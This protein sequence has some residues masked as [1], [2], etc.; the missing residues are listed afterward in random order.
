MNIDM[1]IHVWDEGFH[2]QKFKLARAKEVA[3]RR[4]PFRDPLTLLPRIMADGVDPEGVLLMQEMTKAGIDA[5]VAMT[6]DVGIA[7]GDEQDTPVEKV[8][9]HHHHLT[10]KYKG[11]F[12]AFFGVDPRRPGALKLFEKSVREWDF[13]GL[14]LYP[15]CGYFPADDV[16]KPFLRTCVDLGV[17]VL[18]HT[19]ALVVPPL[20]SRYAHPMYVSDIAAEFPDL[21][22][23]YGHMGFPAWAEDAAAVAQMH[24]WSYM[25]LSQWN[26][27]ALSH[28]ERFIPRLAAIRDMV[29]AHRILFASDY[30][31]GPGTA[32]NRSKYAEWVQ[33]I[34]DLSDKAPQYGCKF[35][36]DEVN[37]ILGGNAQRILR[38]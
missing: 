28:P 30:S 12:Y 4:L 20:R 24:S 7:I 21:R 19:S 27:E 8:M 22:I 25:E 1:H 13:K 23:I 2:P 38:L 36:S 9:E 14:K 31:A 26:R 17:P 15:P 33:F 10:Q 16:C 32:G 29:G 6:M 18:V 5:V 3:H 37:L 11:R 34:R 35:T